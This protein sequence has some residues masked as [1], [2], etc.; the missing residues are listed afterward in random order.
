M[1]DAEVTHDRKVAVIIATCGVTETEARQALDEH[2]GQ[3][4]AVMSLFS[5]DNKKEEATIS[6]DISCSSNSRKFNDSHD[7]DYTIVPHEN[8]FETP[9]DQSGDGRAG[10]DGAIV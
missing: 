7:D 6:D 10:N 4:D 9:L 8:T 1:E 5:G 2:G 3:V